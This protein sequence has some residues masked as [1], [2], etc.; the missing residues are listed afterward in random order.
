MFCS[1]ILMLICDNLQQ[2]PSCISSHSMWG[3]IQV[4]QSSSPHGCICK[5]LLQSSCKYKASKL[6]LQ[7][8]TLIPC[9]F[10]CFFISVSMKNKYVLW[11]LLYSYC[12]WT[13]TACSQIR[14]NEIHSY[15]NFLISTSI[16]MS[17]NFVESVAE[18]KQGIKTY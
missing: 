16:Q 17:T 1:L 11:T 7:V 4:L 15:W 10:I 18:N 6:R 12:N 2:E 8:L 5:V 3:R 13:S 14:K 9:I